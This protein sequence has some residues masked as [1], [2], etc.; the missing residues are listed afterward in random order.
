MD[1]SWLILL[2]C[3]LMMF[4]MMYFMMKGNH[5]ESSQQNQHNAMTEQLAELKTQNESIKKEL[6]ELKNS[7]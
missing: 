1:W 5:T 2:L 6:H 3:P 7:N 4:P